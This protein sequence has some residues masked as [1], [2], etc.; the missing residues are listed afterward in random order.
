MHTTAAALLGLLLLDLS[1]RAA[2]EMPALAAAREDAA[3][4]N[5]SRSLP[6][7]TNASAS[8][9]FLVP[10]PV[11]GILHAPGARPPPE[12]PPGDPGAGA[13]EEHDRHQEPGRKDPTLMVDRGHL[14]PPGPASAADHRSRIS[15]LEGHQANIEGQ[16]AEIREGLLAELKVELAAET[17]ELRDRI[18]VLEQ[19]EGG[20]CE[21]HLVPEHFQA[22]QRGQQT[23]KGAAAAGGGKADHGVP[24]GGDDAVEEEAA[25]AAVEGGG[26]MDPEQVA[27][28]TKIQAIQRGRQSRKGAAGG[29]KAEQGEPPAA[30]EP[31][32]APA[33]AAMA[34][35]QVAP[36]SSDGVFGLLLAALG[37]QVRG[38]KEMACRVG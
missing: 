16:L 11:Q 12:R 28:A 7:E 18:E 6:V 24:A 15:A 5:S 25:P 30:A 32:A 20:P 37:M 17:S 19:N 13:P 9:P 3:A 31:A 4:R 10:S 14:A 35:E 26:E 1:A 33:A 27:A 29:G 22:I 21:T 36:R 23:R 38:T 8:P 34:A 2:A